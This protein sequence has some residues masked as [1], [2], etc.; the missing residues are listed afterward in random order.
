MEEKYKIFWNFFELDNENKEKYKDFE[1]INKILE[2]SWN[3][4]NYDTIYDSYLNYFQ[5]SNDYSNYTEIDFQIKY[6]I[7]EK[8]IAVNKI[9]EFA[10]EKFKTRYKFL[11]DILKKSNLFSPIHNLSWML[12]VSKS[13]IDIDLFIKNLLRIES[14]EIF[15]KFKELNWN[16]NS[17]YLIGFNFKNDKNIIN[18]I[19]KFASDI[20]DFSIEKINKDTW[21]IPYWIGLL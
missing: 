17:T 8:K 3:K 19:K 20:E 5:G 2:L 12:A 18:N 16:S 1:N 21:M 14:W 15:I 4:N 7:D 13:E 9:L 11:H 10:W 6:L